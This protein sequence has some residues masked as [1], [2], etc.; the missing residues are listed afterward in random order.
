MPGRPR[1]SDW[2]IISFWQN[3]SGHQKTLLYEKEK[4]FLLEF[5]SQEEMGFLRF[6]ALQVRAPAQNAC[7]TEL[8]GP[9]HHL[10]KH[11]PRALLR[12]HFVGFHSLWYG[13]LSLSSLLTHGV[14]FTSTGK[15]L[16]FFSPPTYW[17][18]APEIRRINFNGWG[19][20]STQKGVLCSISTHGILQV[21]WEVRSF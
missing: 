14:L 16:D 15:E 1:K 19:I 4:Q 11:M 3:R 2:D 21:R 17:A 5:K 12:C 20:N 9:L 6:N 8:Q 13:E 18:G 7:S 10:E